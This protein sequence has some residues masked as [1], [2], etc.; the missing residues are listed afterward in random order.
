MSR[1]RAMLAVLEASDQSTFY[2][3]AADGTRMQLMPDGNRGSSRPGWLERGADDGVG[4]LDRLSHLG[5]VV[6]PHDVDACVDGRGDGGGS[7]EQPI[8]DLWRWSPPRWWT[9]AT[10]R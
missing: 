8:I 5:G 1:C 4:H 2:S 10:C 6:H 3:E 9:C 7:A